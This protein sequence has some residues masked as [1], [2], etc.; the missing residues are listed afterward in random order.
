MPRLWGAHAFLYVMCIKILLHYDEYR[1]VHY[2]IYVHHDIELL[3]LR[4]SSS[5]S[6]R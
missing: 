1:C 3:S 2:N 4:G 5:M 6:V